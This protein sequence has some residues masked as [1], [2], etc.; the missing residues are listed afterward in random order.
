MNEETQQRPCRQEI[1]LAVKR[2]N[3]SVELPAYAYRGDAGLDLRSTIDLVLQPFERALIPTGLAIALPEGYAGFVQPRSGRA[4]KEGLS[5][6]NT[7][8]LIDSHYRGELKIIA[9]NLDATT[10]IEIKKGER[11]AQLVIQEVPVVKLKE[12][13]EL[14]ETDRGSGG[15]GSS[16]K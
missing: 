14:D 6:V 10:P 13:D 3:D 5:M 1:E 7:P 8:G 12:V 2:L 15:F 9:V 16:G 11:V 4:L